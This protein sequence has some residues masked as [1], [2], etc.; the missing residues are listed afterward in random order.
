MILSQIF[1]IEVH[2]TFDRQY[3]WRVQSSIS[4]SGLSRSSGWADTQDLGQQDISGN[5]TI[6]VHWHSGHLTWTSDFFMKQM[7]EPSND[8]VVYWGYHG[9][10]SYLVCAE[11]YE[12]MI[13]WWFENECERHHSDEMGSSHLLLKSLQTSSRPLFKWIHHGF[14]E[15]KTSR[16]QHATVDPFFVRPRKVH[17]WTVEPTV[18][19]TCFLFLNDSPAKWR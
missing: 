12:S 8:G 3:I 7:N 15:T 9:E 4:S 16:S 5:H 11:Q 1:P 18:E 6:V 17:L 19:V 2:Y 10:I 14:L 13:I